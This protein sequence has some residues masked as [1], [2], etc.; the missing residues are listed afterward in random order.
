MD[1][2]WKFSISLKAFANVRHGNKICELTNALYIALYKMKK[3]VACVLFLL[4]LHVSV[5]CYVHVSVSFNCWNKIVCVHIVVLIRTQNFD[6]ESIINWWNIDKILYFLV[7]TLQGHTTAIHKKCVTFDF[8]MVPKKS[9][10][11]SILLEELKTVFIAWK[12]SEILFFFKNENR[13]SNF[14]TIFITS[15]IKQN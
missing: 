7:Y 9:N 11:S 4:Y 12:K 3:F 8:L 1:R 15:S 10:F 5:I 2:K 13:I 6:Q 14:I